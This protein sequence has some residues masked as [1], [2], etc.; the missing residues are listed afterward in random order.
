MQKSSKTILTLIFA[1]VV[2]WIGYRLLFPPPVSDDRQIRNQIAGSIS[3]AQDKNVSGIMAP[4][5]D[6]FVD[7]N[8]YN[9]QQLRLMLS[10][11]IHDYRSITVTP[12]NL[13]V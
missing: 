11:S 10:Q 12:S 5:S 4:V 13:T 7:S 2:L 9:S 8:G 1:L 6:S 3:A